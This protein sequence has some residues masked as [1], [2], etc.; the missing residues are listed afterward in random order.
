ML[1]RKKKKI[2]PEKIWRDLVKSG[3]KIKR[4]D[5]VIKFKLSD[6]EVE[7]CRYE[8]IDKNLRL[9]ECTVHRGEC[10]H[11]VKLWPI[12]LWEIKEGLVYQ[13]VNGEW[14]LWKPNF[15]NNLKRFET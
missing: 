8:V 5:E 7:K 15:K 2:D 14:I 10:S 3:K 6:K 12:H 1:S 9:A 11:G 13:K 4:N